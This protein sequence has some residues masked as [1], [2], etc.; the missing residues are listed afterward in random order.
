LIHESH[1]LGVQLLQARNQRAWLYNP[2]NASVT[3]ISTGNKEGQSCI[4][5]TKQEISDK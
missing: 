1:R 2:V 3:S 5:K 4:K